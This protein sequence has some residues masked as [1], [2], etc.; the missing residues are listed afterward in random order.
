[1]VSESCGWPPT[2]VLDSA[3]PW[4]LRPAVCLL[5]WP[6]PTPQARLPRS[7]GRR[8]E[9]VR[10]PV[11]EV[12]CLASA[13]G[14]RDQLPSLLGG[15][16]TLAGRPRARMISRSA[17]G[18]RLLVIRSA[19]SRRPVSTLLAWRGRCQCA[20]LRT[21]GSGGPAGAAAPS[22]PRSPPAAGRPRCGPRRPG[23]PPAWL[24]PERDVAGR[25][26]SAPGAGCVPFSGRPRVGRL[27]PQRPGPRGWPPRPAAG[28][29]ARQG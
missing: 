6:G 7:R 2:M 22:S 4:P 23:G 25:R 26:G 15:V 10:P 9:A 19:S 20:V 5:E 16:R 13:E 8:S 24:P 1:M 18:L 27:P 17:L 3:G 29:P 21:D 28:L 14:L 12:S 11:P